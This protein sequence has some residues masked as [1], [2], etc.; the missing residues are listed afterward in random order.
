MI[1]R[2]VTVSNGLTRSGAV[3][4]MRRIVK[5][6]VGFALLVAG[7]VLLPLPGPGLLLIALG[8]AVL[9]AEFAWARNL[10]NRIKHQVERLRP[11]KSRRERRDTP[12]S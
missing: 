12:A 6:V 2:S 10:L 7:V 4:R 1:Q 11:K 5:I 9:A 3:A 8:L